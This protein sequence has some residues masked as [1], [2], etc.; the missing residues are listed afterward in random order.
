MIIERLFSWCQ[1]DTMPP[2]WPKITVFGQ[3]DPFL[4]HFEPLWR[5]FEPL[6]RGFEAIREA[7]GGRAEVGVNDYEFSL[8]NDFLFEWIQMKKMQTIICWTIKYNK[9]IEWIFSRLNKSLKMRNIDERSSSIDTSFTPITVL[10][11]ISQ[12]CP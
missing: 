5:D 1:T 7:F 8:M 3:F 9:K 6:W 10:S 2:K 11:L 12:C 4:S